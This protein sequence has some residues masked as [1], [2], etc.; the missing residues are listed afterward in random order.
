[1]WRV[2]RNKTAG[3]KRTLVVTASLL[4]TSRMAMADGK[5]G[6]TAAT[7]AVN[8]YFDVGTTLM[9]TIGA[10]TGLVGAIK[11]YQKWSNGEQDTHK[12]A[13]AWFASCIFLVVVS[14]VLRAFFLT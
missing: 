13:S 4:L 3:W 1:M 7:T 5:T 2:N 11:V 6:I 10:V 14:A 12:S 8:G 9:L